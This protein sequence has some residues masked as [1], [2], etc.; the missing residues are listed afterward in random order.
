[1]NKIEEI[2][3]FIKEEEIDIAFISESHDR[4]NKRLGDHMKLSDHITISN[5]YQRSSN[6]KGGRPAIIANKKKYI[7]ENLTNTSVTIPW[8]VEIT[9]ALL[10]PKN[11]T[12]DSTIQK[13]VLGAVYMKPNS[14]KKTTLLDH[15]AE[16]HASLGAKYGRG[17]HWIITG[18]TND[19]KLGPILEINQNFKNQ[20]DQTQRIQKRVQFLIT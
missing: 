11:V 10:T 15:I 3:D 6:V 8:G 17:L 7:I 2:T 1:M 12:R 16:V 14:K 5:I 20:Q 19:L 18:D 4:E 13:I 9:W